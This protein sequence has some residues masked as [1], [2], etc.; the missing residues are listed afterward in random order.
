MPAVELGESRLVAQLEP[1]DQLPV[2]VD[3]DLIEGVGRG[4]A[5]WRHP[6]SHRGG[7]SDPAT[8]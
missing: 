8:A 3:V 2:T 1:V 6:L 4:A 7:S 5:Q